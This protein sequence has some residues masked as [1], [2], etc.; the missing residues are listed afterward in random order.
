MNKIIITLTKCVECEY[1]DH[2]GQYSSDI[3]YVCRKNYMKLGTS[4]YPLI[5]KIGI[6]GH[7]FIQ[8]LNEMSRESQI[9]YD[10]GAIRIM[11]LPEKI[12]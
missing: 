3:T 12:S 7:Q 4:P 10:N 1:F 6:K 2:I 5:R 9:L 11:K 8:M